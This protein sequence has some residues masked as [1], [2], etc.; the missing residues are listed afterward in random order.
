MIAEFTDVDVFS[1]IEKKVVRIP[2][3]AELAACLAPDLNQFRLFLGDIEFLNSVV[4]GVSDPQMIELVNRQTL[5]TAKLSRFATVTAPLAEEI[6]VGRKLL[7]AIE[8]TIFGNVRIACGILHGVR[9][10]AKLARFVSWPT[11]DSSLR[12]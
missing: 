10:E 1:V 2:E 9:D 8:F 5:R 6:S 11:A 7:D 4:A 12:L 3:L